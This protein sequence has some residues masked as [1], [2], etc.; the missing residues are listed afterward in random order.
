PYRREPSL[1]RRD[2]TARRLVVG[3][4]V[5]TLLGKPD[6]DVPARGGRPHRGEARIESL[7][8]IDRAGAIASHCKTPFSRP[9]ARLHADAESRVGGR[10][11][12][13]KTQYGARSRRR[14]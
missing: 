1:Q 8:S 3:G 5:A 10:A 4:A 7:R 13:A 2:P 6:P 9:R 11:A 12:G 14:A